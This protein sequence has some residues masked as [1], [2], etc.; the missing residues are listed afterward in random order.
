VQ[1]TVRN[2]STK[3]IITVTE[4]STIKIG[5]GDLFHGK[6]IPE[7]AFTDIKYIVKS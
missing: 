7:L 4:I 3:T 6:V 5:L 1:C 2:H